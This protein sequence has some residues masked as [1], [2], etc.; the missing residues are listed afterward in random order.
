VLAVLTIT[1]DRNSAAARQR[2]ES[3]QWW[4]AHTLSVLIAAEAADTALNKALR[5][6]RGYVLTAKPRALA[7]F[8]DG[9]ADYHRLARRLRGLTPDNGSQQRRVTELDR[10]VRSFTATAVPVVA[11]VKAGRTAEALAAAR[12]GRERETLEDATLVLDQIKTEETRLL[13]LRQAMSADAAARSERFGQIILWFD[14]ALLLMIACAVAAVLWGRAAAGRTAAAVATNERLL[15]M[16][17][18]VGK[19]GHWRLDTATGAMIWSDEILRIYGFAPGTVPTVENAL[20]V[21]HPD[22]VA[23]VRGTLQ[24][25][26]VD[27][28]GYHSYARVIRPDGEIVSVLTRA[29]IELDETGMPVGFFG[30]VQDISAQVAAQAA[31]SD[32]ERQYRLLAENATDVVL[33]T[34]DDGVV[35]YASPSCLELS[36]FTP[37]EL[38][39]QHCASFIHQDEQAAVHLAHVTIVQGIQEAV[40]VQYRLK[41]KDGGWR[42]LES[43]MRGWQ[44]PDGVCEGV[45]SAIRDVEARKALEA[46]LVAARET[47]EAAAHAKSNF[48]ANMSH[49]IRTPMNGVVGFTELLL[50]GD[51]APDQRRRAELIADSSRSMVRLL[52]DILDLSKIEAGQMSVG[53]EPFDLIHALKACVRLVKPAVEQKGVDLETELSTA[54]PQM[55]VGDGLR[56]RQVV[57]NL[58]GNAAKFTREGRITLRARLSHQ[59][60]AAHVVIEVEDSGPGIAADRQAAIF[61]RFVQ[62][63]VGVAPAFGGS[64]LGLPISVQLARLMG[65]DIA[66][67][68]EEGRG[69]RF[70]LTLPLEVADVAPAI[71]AVQSLGTGG[72][73]PAHSLGK[74]LRVLVAEDHDVNQL[75]VSEMLERL[76]CAAEIAEN[77]EVA[78]TMI[79]AADRQSRPY[80]IV[81]MDMQMPRLGGVE[82]TRRLRASGYD[83]GRLPIVALTANAY[84]DDVEACLQAGM[85]SHLAKPLQLRDLEAVLRRW[86]AAPPR[87]EGQGT[88]QFSEKIRDRYQL[89]RDETLR[90]VDELVRSGEFEGAAVE[91]VTELLHKL[92]GTAGMFGEAELGDRARDLEQ[93]LSNWPAAVRAERT[94]GMATLLRAAA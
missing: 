66:L 68:S 91:E 45:I 24:K 48:L 21:Y 83:A 56:L 12:V 36:G 10:R 43:H 90:K 81:L 63:D 44:G 80:S 2:Q 17:Q 82:A 32:S 14:G 55:V 33:R 62:A 8:E 67:E 64:G 9:L 3:A 84:A 65:G 19:L 93:G 88:V 41:Q 59:R 75:L 53:H 23:R 79:A 57:L 74:S 4:R 16:A 39:G 49:E 26:L 29:E 86:A 7:T 6:E 76:G 78:L 42:W 69:A 20:A 27:R 18:S 73:E 5:G 31:L 89:R 13:K 37:F 52:N 60:G 30:V 35:L 51:L 61:E 94:R 15:T 58:L 38:V 77:G 40:T 11:L 70:I 72:D 22:D 50:A 25:A 71:A 54:L 46:E 1:L 34:G 47:A 92:A 28:T 85:Q 87:K